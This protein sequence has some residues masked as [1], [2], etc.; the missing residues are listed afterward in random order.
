MEFFGNPSLNLKVLLF[1]L[2]MLCT[3][4]IFWLLVGPRFIRP[5]C[6]R[7]WDKKSKGQVARTIRF[8]GFLSF[9]GEF[10]KMAV[11]VAAFIWVFLYPSNWYWFVLLAAII[12]CLLSMCI[13][14]ATLAMEYFEYRF[15]ERWIYE[16]YFNK[17]NIPP[18]A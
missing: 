5:W 4:R 14:T 16:K 2:F 9:P 12:D 6:V 15:L 13:R 1:V 18:R 17:N 8:L 3:E 7:R 11:S 10:I